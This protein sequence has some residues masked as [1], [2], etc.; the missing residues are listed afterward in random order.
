VPVTVYGTAHPD[1]V[2]YCQQGTV[3]AVNKIE[4]R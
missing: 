4:R 3:L 2:S 1:Q